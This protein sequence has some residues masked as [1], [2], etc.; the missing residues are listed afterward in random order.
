[1]DLGAPDLLYPLEVPGVPD[2]VKLS[3]P[4]RS[5]QRQ[6]FEVVTIRQV[7][8]TLIAPDGSRVLVKVPLLAWFADG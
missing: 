1:M 2:G 6:R 8:R 4:T 5:A 7:E 3:D